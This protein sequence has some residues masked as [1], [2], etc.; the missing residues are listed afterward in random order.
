[1]E[2]SDVRRRRHG[3]RLRVAFVDHSSLPGG[4]QLGL[5][6]FLEHPIKTFD[7]ALVVVE[8]G[9]LASWARN[10]GIP[11]TEVFPDGARVSSVSRR[12][13]GLSRILRGLEADVVIANSLISAMLL[14]LTP[15]R[16]RIF[17]YYLR[18]DLSKQ[19]L[20]GM[21]RNF[22]T[23][24]SLARFDGYLANSR[25]T[26]ST[27]PAR[28]R[29][30]PW[31]IAYPISG[32][33]ERN[34]PEIHVPADHEPVRVLS[35]SRLTP[36]KGID[37]LIQAIGVLQARGYANRFLVTVAGGDLFEGDGYAQTLRSI[38]DPLN[39]AVTFV[40]HV[41]AVEDELRRHHIL[42]S[43]SRLPEPFGQV[44]VQGMSHGLLT[45]ATAQGGPTEI[46]RDGVD[47]HLIRPG[48]PEALADRIEG[49]LDVAQS[50]SL[51]EHGVLRANL[52][53][54]ETTVPQL[55]AAIVDLV[56]EIRSR[57]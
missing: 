9:E 56:T 42:V 45:I 33:N 48:D 40:G 35:L 52:F 22:V 15:K 32:V 5:R 17:V 4:G 3:E 29:R 37:V 43:G 46:I 30:R 36:W 2:S 57:R 53:A 1:M 24:F 20:T 19:W 47:G 14:S 7:A 10:R 12:R 25:W 11:V 18:E 34:V 39:G 41:D 16:G 6:R 51:R 49:F 55:E 23:V 44:I 54:D 27:I 31:R 21:K 50:S 8:G 13:A 38:A 26:A 28:Y